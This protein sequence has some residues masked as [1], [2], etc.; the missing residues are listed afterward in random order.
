MLSEI[1]FPRKK[2]K[3]VPGEKKRKRYPIHDVNEYTIHTSTDLNTS[4]LCLNSIFE[5]V[6]WE[7]QRFLDNTIM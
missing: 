6:L 7:L 4:I 2:K 3:K 5:P 1:T